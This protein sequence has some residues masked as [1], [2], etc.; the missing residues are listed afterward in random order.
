MSNFT[1]RPAERKRAKLRLCLS[2]PSGSGKTYSSLLIASGLVPWSK[3][4][5]LDT[6]HSSAELYANLGN[7]S[8]LT[9]EPPYDPLR[10]VEAIKAAEQAGFE[11]LIIDSLSHA[12]NGEGGILDQQGK[13]TD[14]KYR[15]NSFSA[16]RE[17]TPKHNA[18]INA[19]LASNLHIIAT[20]RSKTEYSLVDEN[21]KK[22]VKKLGLAPVQREGVDYEFSV[23]MELSI[24]HTAIATKDRTSIFDGKYFKPNRQVGE[25]LLHWL[26]NTSNSESDATPQSCGLA[27]PPS[28][29]ILPPDENTLVDDF[30]V[31]SCDLKASQS[32]RRIV[33]LSLLSRSENIAAWSDDLELLQLKT[34]AKIEARLSK[35]NDAWIIDSYTPVAAGERNLA[36]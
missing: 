30:R 10:Y 29:F 6:E 7:Y 16:W 26:N 18:L 24:D 31:M 23:F 32:G 8:T 1:F 2:G 21:G 36:A 4:A 3:I 13:V 17:F 9:L 35:K 25:R 34:G 19:I 11:V 12:W 27:V 15:G 20:V 28:T 22:Q 5:V 14:T 33:K